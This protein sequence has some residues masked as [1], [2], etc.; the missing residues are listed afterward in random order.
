MEQNHKMAKFSFIKCE[1]RTS[2]ILYLNEELADVNFVFNRYIKS[3][4]KFFDHQLPSDE[5]SFSSQRKTLLIDKRTWSKRN[6]DEMC[7]WIATQQGLNNLKK[8]YDQVRGLPKPINEGLWLR[9]SFDAVAMKYGL[10]DVYYASEYSHYHLIGPN[11]SYYPYSDVEQGRKGWK[12]VKNNEEGFGLIMWAVHPEQIKGTMFDEENRKELIMGSE[13]INILMDQLENVQKNME[14]T[15]D[16]EKIESIR[17]KSYIPYF[18]SVLDLKQEHLELVKIW[19]RDMTATLRNFDVSEEKG[20]NV[21]LYFHW[22]YADDSVTLHIHARV[23][24]GSHPLEEKESITVDKVIEILEQEKSVE[25]YI[26]EKSLWYTT[27]ED[28]HFLSQIHGINP[29]IVPNTF[30]LDSR[31]VSNP[32]YKKRQK[33]VEVAAVQVADVVDQAKG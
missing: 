33:A 3:C 28:Y 30:K 24:Q 19:K 6:V 16:Q 1:S 5:I 22:P 9:N 31:E 32:S 8:F 14:R 7:K 10:A 12:N 29:E 23:N 15:K 20:D 27:P 11:P 17:N 25:E 13:K 18:A 21:R 4:A 26:L 2:E